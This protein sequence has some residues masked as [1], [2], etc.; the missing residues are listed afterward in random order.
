MKIDGP[1]LD[2]VVV[3]E[4]IHCTRI[5]LR[6]GKRIGESPDG[7]ESI[8]FPGEDGPRYLAIPE[9]VKITME[10][11]E[12]RVKHLG[13]AVRAAMMGDETAMDY[14]GWNVDRQTSAGADF[15][16]LNV[17]EVSVK[18]DE[19]IAAM[20][21]LVKTVQRMTDVPLSIDSSLMETITAGFEAHDHSRRRPLLNSASLERIDALMSK[22]KSKRS[23]APAGA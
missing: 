22:V 20:R 2:F 5:L 6:K 16:D 21:W 19:Q 14:L 9:D 4:N 15:L 1:D 17:D 18:P 13:I 23:L 3:G 7:R 10:Y 11:Q 12:G 8:V